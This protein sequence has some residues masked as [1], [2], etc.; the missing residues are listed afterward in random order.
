MLHDY[1]KVELNRW[2]QAAEEC[3]LITL[4]SDRQEGVLRAE[5]P[6]AR[7]EEV[8]VLWSDLQAERSV[9]SPFRIVAY[10]IYDGLENRCGRSVDQGHE[11]V[12]GQMHCAKTNDAYRLEMRL[13]AYSLS[14]LL[15]SAMW[16]SN[17]DDFLLV[18]ML[19]WLDSKGFHKAGSRLSAEWN[20][21]LHLF[22]ARQNP[23]SPSFR[24][25]KFKT[26]D[27]PKLLQRMRDPNA[28]VFFSELLAWVLCDHD[29]LVSYLR[30]SGIL[31]NEMVKNWY[32]RS[33]DITERF[34]RFLE[35][36]PRCYQ[37]FWTISD[38]LIDAGLIPRDSPPA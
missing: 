10:D 27:K 28:P 23:P 33:I 19:C 3:V 21:A 4:T 9:N 24:P 31:R 17:A 34:V 11:L 20:E 6:Y 12:S 35:S 14:V 13:D 38:D 32:C 18:R 16:A 22:E 1:F 5:T 30:E 29:T 36:K 37:K 26:F 25:M 7:P 2:Q 15:I 8:D